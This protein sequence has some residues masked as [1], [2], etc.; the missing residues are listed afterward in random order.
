MKTRKLR[1]PPSQVNTHRRKFLLGGASFAAIASTSFGASGQE[2]E[3]EILKFEPFPKRPFELLNTP[4]TWL[5]HQET[6]YSGLRWH[7]KV[8][9]NYSEQFNPPSRVVFPGDARVNFAGTSSQAKVDLE[10]FTGVWATD[11]ELATNERPAMYGFDFSRCTE[12]WIDGS[13]KVRTI[14]EAPLS[15]RNDTS[16]WIPGERAMMKDLICST[17]Y[18]GGEVTISFHMLNPFFPQVSSVNDGGDLGALFTFRSGSPVM[19]DP[20][21]FVWNNVEVRDYVGVRYRYLGEMLDEILDNPNV[22][23]S[24][25]IYIRPFHEPNVQ[26]FWWGQQQGEAQTAGNFLWNYHNLFCYA[27]DKIVEGL[28]GNVQAKLA[29][30]GFVFAINTDPGNNLVSILDDYIPANP[31]VGSLAEQFVNGVEVLG[32]DYYQDDGPPSANPGHPTLATE[33]VRVKNKANAMGYEHALTEVGMR[34]SGVGKLYGDTQAGQGP[35]PSSG[36]NFFNSTIKPLVTQHDPKWVLFWAN[37][38]GN[39]ALSVLTPT[40]SGTTNDSGLYYGDAPT[41]GFGC[42][43]VLTQPEAEIYTPLSPVSPFSLTT[44][45]SGGGLGTITIPGG[46]NAM[47]YIPGAVNRAS[48]CVPLS[49]LSFTTEGFVH[50]DAV[51]DFTAMMNTSTGPTFITL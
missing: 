10:G 18:K 13:G 31:P 30:L 45:L 34:A 46:I 26:F 48:N 32:L 44:Y 19:S 6:L 42:L 49:T 5:G 8:P 9:A 11:V 28:T 15:E 39:S 22:P 43:N 24:K 41:T 2:F 37:R 38:L 17:L 14:L 23:S 40:E 1:N 3:R 51:Q 29:R 50:E 4:E 21:N 36:R 12:T 20:G 16:K 47:Q 25:K 35:W 7:L 27:Y 33:Y